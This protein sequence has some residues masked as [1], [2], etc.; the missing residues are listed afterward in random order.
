VGGLYS[1]VNGLYSGVNGFGLKDGGDSSR[2]D[3]FN[4]LIILSSRTALFDLVMLL[5]FFKS[6]CFPIFFSSV[7]FIWRILST[8]R[9]VYSGTISFLDTGDFGTR[10]ETFAGDFDARDFAG[11]FDARLETLETFAGDFDLDRDLERAGDFEARLETFAGD[12]DLDRDLERAG[13]FDARLETFAGDFDRDLERAGDFDD[14]LETFEGDF[15]RDRAGD[16]DPIS[17]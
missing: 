2:S 7:T 1:G 15:E 9:S 6:S 8:V 5:I 12:F 11:D 10:L 14:R 13:D 16:L 3:N 17:K 4:S